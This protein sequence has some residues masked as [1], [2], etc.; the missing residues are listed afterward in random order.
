MIIFKVGDEVEKVLGD[1]YYRGHVVAVFYKL[2][3]VT[4]Y[5]V[6]NSDGMLFIFNEKQIR[7][8]K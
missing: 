6:E 2:N 1:Y 5:V 3:G 4:R 7:L 8:V